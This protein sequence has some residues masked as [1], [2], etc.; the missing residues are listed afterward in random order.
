MD[1]IRYFAA[2]LAVVVYPPAVF[3]WI[4]VHPLTGFWRRIGLAPSYIII[5]AILVGI[6]MGIYHFRDVILAVD[7]GT[8]W[9]LISLAAILFGAGMVI[10]IRCRRQ[11]SLSTLVGLPELKPE[12]SSVELLKDGIYGQVRHPKYA[13]AALGL[14][15]IAFFTNYFATYLLIVICLPA[16]Y[17]I[18]VLEERELIDRFGEECR[19][20]Q[21]NVPRFIPRRSD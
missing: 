4:L 12:S 6:A 17:L 19:E 2:L 7:F 8:N 10:E 9:L 14:I 3:F 1:D 5:V 16:L 18:T 13:G 15:A 21:K 20:Y 11:L